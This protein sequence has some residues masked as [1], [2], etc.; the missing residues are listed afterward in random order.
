MTDK[1]LCRRL[2]IIGTGRVAHALMLAL[3]PYADLPPL[4]WGRSREQAEA[5]A[6]EAAGAATTDLRAIADACDLIV[7]AV[8]DDAVAAMA[9]ELARDLAPP[10]APF[11]FHVSGR[12]G[13]A[14]LDPLAAAGAQIAAIHP[15]MTFTGN[16]RTEIERMA[17]AHFAVTVSDPAT[18]P[19]ARGVIE[20]LGGTAVEIAEA[21][22]TLYHAALC[23][24]ANHLVTLLAGASQALRTAGADAPE[25]MLAPLVRAALENSLAHGFS[26]LSG[27]LLRGD[28]D[29]IARHLAAID[30]DCPA[31][32]APYRAMA[33]ATLDE[34]ER[35]GLAAASPAIRTLLN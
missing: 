32:G 24:A 25:A 16:P 1:R 23:H 11:V 20:R 4:V 22:R 3:A 29:T 30:A 31:L 6:R 26:A 10:H 35:D 9:A 14:I 34:M 28:G 17:A 19:R 18:L 2:G 27:P 33:R 5:L 7:I 15:V 21:Q 8:A 13:A 12:S